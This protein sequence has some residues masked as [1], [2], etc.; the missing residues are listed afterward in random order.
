[1]FLLF[2]ILLCSGLNPAQ[3]SNIEKYQFISPLPGSKLIMP[4][5]NIIIRQG[6]IIDATTIKE[7]SI[8]VIGSISGL[9]TGEF[10]LSDDNRTLIFIP[11]IHFTPGEKVN[12]KVY[13]G[14]YT[15]NG[16]MFSP[17]TFDFNIS[18]TIS[19]NERERALNDVS[20]FQTMST[21]TEYHQYSVNVSRPNN[22]DLPE[23]FPPITVN[24]NNNPSNGYLFLAPFSPNG[25]IAPTPEI[26]TLLNCLTSFLGNCYT[27]LFL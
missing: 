2:I 21:I 20:D 1:M 12:V 26:T 16:E 18:Q 17:I 23:D 13:S 5:N 11:S 19:K 25:E 22:E 4:E 9:H 3:D 27:H 6:D 24:V 10:F 14:I 7:E 8:E 15:A